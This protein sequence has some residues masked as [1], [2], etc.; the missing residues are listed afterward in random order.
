MK[1][2]SDPLRPRPTQDKRGFFMLPQ[3]PMDSGYYVYR[4]DDSGPACGKRMDD[5]RQ[6]ANRH[7]RHQLG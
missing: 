6:Q 5:G 1:H 2:D 4:H 3:T 7:R